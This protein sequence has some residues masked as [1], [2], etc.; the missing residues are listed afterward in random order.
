MI[1][2]TRMKLL[3][4]KLGINRENFVNVFNNL[5]TW[6]MYSYSDI[7]LRLKYFSTMSNKRIVLNT[8]AWYSRFRLN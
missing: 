4:S 2:K 1:L 3:I 8:S 7:L 6:E 5:F